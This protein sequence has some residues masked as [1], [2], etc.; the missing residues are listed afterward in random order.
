MAKSKKKKEKVKPD[1]NPPRDEFTD[2]SQTTQY[3]EENPLP[4]L[5]DEAL[6][7]KRDFKKDWK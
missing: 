4:R 6:N 7:A 5:L 3:H 2:D 1:W